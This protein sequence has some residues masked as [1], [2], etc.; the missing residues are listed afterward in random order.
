MAYLRQYKSAKC[1]QVVAPFLKRR[2]I[3]AFSLLVNRISM[4]EPLMDGYS[5]L[6]HL[7][8][9]ENDSPYRPELLVRRIFVII[10]G[11][12]AISRARSYYRQYASRTDVS[13][14]FV[15]SVCDGKN[16]I[17]T[18]E[19]DCCNRRHTVYVV[20]SP[21]PS[22]DYSQFFSQNAQIQS[23]SQGLRYVKGMSS[24]PSNDIVIKIRAD[25]S[26]KLF[27]FIES[28]SS[29]QRILS[30][31]H[32]STFR[33]W[34]MDQHTHKNIP[35]GF[36]DSVQ[37]S[38]VDK[39]CNYW[40]VELICKETIMLLPK[41]ISDCIESNCFEPYYCWSYLEKV[42]YQSCSGNHE[43][44][45]MDALRDVFGVLPSVDTGY[46]WPKYRN[47]KSRDLTSNDPYS[48]YLDFHE[49][50]SLLG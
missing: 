3:K 12:N 26:V 16:E 33:I 5:L 15:A 21:L 30:G 10:H 4:L 38:T 29:F 18:L 42:G 8:K 39:L 32:D 50:L 23:V 25:A 46:Y 40:D 24:D 48:Q 31:Y 36:C 22:T 9:W 7:V 19:E 17:P 37:L 27:S 2:L 13:F 47:G 49:W 11:P 45:Y 1:I 20:R 44:R 43:R 35:Y 14:T 6:T 41:Q 28:A 34:G